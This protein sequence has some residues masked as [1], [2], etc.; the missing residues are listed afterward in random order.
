MPALYLSILIVTKQM[1]KNTFLEQLLFHL[2]LFVKFEMMGEAQ[3]VDQTNDI[4]LPC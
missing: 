1:G 3:T 4:Q 2:T